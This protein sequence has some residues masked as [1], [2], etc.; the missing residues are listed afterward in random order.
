MLDEAA[1]LH[2]PRHPGRW[3][4]FS[5]L[6]SSEPISGRI[7]IYIYMALS[8]YRGSVLRD[9]GST[10]DSKQSEHVSFFGLGL[11][12]GHVPTFWLLL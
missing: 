9:F 11:E 12:E 8:L 2:L 6:R 5:R 4:R 7:H 3:R 10:V 1:V